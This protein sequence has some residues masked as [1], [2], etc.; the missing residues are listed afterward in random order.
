[1]NAFKP[2]GMYYKTLRSRNLRKIDRFCNKL[3]SFLLSVVNTLAYYSKFLIVQ[4]PGAKISLIWSYKN[5]T[6]IRYIFPKIF[7][8]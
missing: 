6:I 3:V 5:L 8:F 2:K 7:L 1:V 4:A